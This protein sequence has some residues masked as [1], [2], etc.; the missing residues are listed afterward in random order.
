MDQSQDNR[1]RLGQVRWATCMRYTRRLMW[2]DFL[3]FGRATAES[4]DLPKKC[5]ISHAYSDSEVC[6]RLI[7]KLGHRTKPILYPPITVPPNQLVSTPLI[8]ALVSCDGLIY[9]SGGQSDRSFWVA[10]E[11]DYALRLQ[12]PVFSADP[13]T[14]EVTRCVDPPL[15]L[16]AFASYSRTDRNRVRDV[17]DFLKRER[18]FDVWV[19]VERLEGGMNWQESIQM[20]LERYLE[21]G[22]AVVFWS[23]AT[24]N[25]QSI[26]DELRRAAQ[27]VGNFND[28]VL[29]ARLDDAPLPAFWM[30]FNE[31]S[32]P[33]W[34]DH[35]RSAT[36]RMDDLVVRLYWLIH[37]KTEQRG[38]HSEG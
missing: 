21:R 29:F 33:I 17:C 11:R 19:D 12:K 4:E 2:K 15:D 7:A 31:P 14:L 32:V 28:R 13:V 20:N 18:N 35:E 37:R 22:Y 38:I 5:F 25:S 30:R 16:A 3:G 8:D 24:A 9:L 1:L 26:M 36:Q 34:G 6:N 23:K 10:F 27:K